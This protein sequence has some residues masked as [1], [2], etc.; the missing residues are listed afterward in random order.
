PDGGGW[1]S[2]LQASAC[3]GA[4]RL[5][6][7]DL[8]AMLFHPHEALAR[9]LKLDSEVRAAAVVGA[10]DSSVAVNCGKILVGFEIPV[11]LVDVSIREARGGGRLRSDFQS[12][13]SFARLTV[14]KTV[15]FGSGGLGA[16]DHA[17]RGCLFGGKKRNRLDEHE[18]SKEQQ[19]TCSEP[20]AF[21]RR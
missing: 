12:G 16:D 4:V 8:E 6:A 3:G 13:R 19:P 18:R 15:V 5:D 20:D 10:F 11:G 1:L 9:V 7:E 2:R 17:A 21:H 14:K